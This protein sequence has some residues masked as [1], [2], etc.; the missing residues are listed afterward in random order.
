MKYIDARIE[1]LDFNAVTACNENVLFYLPNMMTSLGDDSEKMIAET[2][3]YLLERGADLEHID[4]NGYTP[5]LNAAWI[6]PDKPM[7]ILMFIKR[8]ANIHAPTYGYDDVAGK[9][10]E[11]LITQTKNYDV[12]IEYLK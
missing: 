10:L 2:M 9:T 11:D 7:L 5:L 6:T 8:G 3:E 12:V 4:D 1:G